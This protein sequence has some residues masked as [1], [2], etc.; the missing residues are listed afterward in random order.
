MEINFNYHY[1]HLHYVVMASLGK[2]KRIKSMSVYFI[3][4]N[5]SIAKRK[6]W[7]VTNSLNST[8]MEKITNEIYRRAKEVM[9]GNLK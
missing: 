8:V 1:S 6:T 4:C 3:R 2:D 7:D 9:G 5:G